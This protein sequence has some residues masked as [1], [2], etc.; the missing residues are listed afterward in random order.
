LTIKGNKKI[1]KKP[2]CKLRI[3]KAASF[4]V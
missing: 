2:L 1:V 4:F 3:C